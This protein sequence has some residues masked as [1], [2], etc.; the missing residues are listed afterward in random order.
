MQDADVA[1][2]SSGRVAACI[3]LDMGSNE[4]L[5]LGVQGM[6]VNHAPVMVETSK[7]LASRN[8]AIYI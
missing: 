5:W 7:Q 4:D 8:A 1:Y 2:R 6:D 3:P